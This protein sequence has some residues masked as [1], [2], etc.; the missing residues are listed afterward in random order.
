MSASVINRSRLS[1]WLPIITAAGVV[2]NGIRLRRNAKGFSSLRPATAPVGESHCFVTAAGVE[3]DEQTRRAASAFARANDLEVV[4][5]VPA[6]LP[7]EPALDLLRGLDARTYR[8]RTFAPGRGACHALLVDVD[9][10]QRA[11]I[12]QTSGLDPVDLA[13][14]TVALKL[15]AST[16]TDVIVAPGLHALPDE[17]SIHAGLRRA[18]EVR[19]GSDVLLVAGPPVAYAA[20]LVGA[21]LNPVWGVAGLVAFGIQPFLVFRGSAFTPRDGDVQAQISRVLTRP[22]KWLRLI[23]GPQPAPSPDPREERRPA[24]AA[25][26]AAGIERFFE[27]RRETCPWCG[28]AD[29]EVRVVS[30]DHIQ[31]KPGEFRLEQCNACKHIFQNPRLTPAGLDFYYR[32]FY[33][34]IGGKLIENTFE[35]GHSGYAA[36]VSMVSAQTTPRRWLDVG[37]GLAHFCA[38]A[39]DILP[40]TEFDGIDRGENIEEAERR[41]WVRRGYRGMFPELA[42]DLAGRYDVV[43][44]HHYLEHTRDPFEEL[45][46]AA[47]VLDAGG[48]LL[49][50]V[51]DPESSF[52]RL[53]GNWWMP[54]LQP[55]HQH[56]IP[57]GN[58]VRALADRGLTTVDVHRAEANQAGDLALAVLL[59]VNSFAHD[60]RLP[61]LP[62]VPESAHG[63]RIAGR[64]AGVALAVPVGGAALLADLA[65]DQ[66]IRRTGGV[67]SIY[68]VLARKDS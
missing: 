57:C 21:V 66:Y 41:R 54:W 22:R 52:G 10:L 31:H 47:K 55:Q 65:C 64:L 63:L 5:L 60:R 51:P 3:L 18:A 40:G 28:S 7:T 49:I 56:L 45:S 20:L 6:D 12:T 2:A 8:G 11:G 35:A 25:D 38:T 59:G 68:R 1:R 24:Y 32:D 50:E 29:V 36:R 16:A 42:D 62:D 58:L 67:G 43:S 17:R 14:K 39:R 61:W 30:P 33:D 34:G 19:M 15:Y 48:Y 44:M 4:D 13:E 53:L 23:T 27:A 46:A 37:T 9:V 26:L